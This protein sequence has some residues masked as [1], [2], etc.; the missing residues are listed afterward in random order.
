MQ[1]TEAGIYDGL[2]MDAY[3]ADCAPAPS[4]SKGIMQTLIERSPLHARAEHPRFGNL[5]NEGS[6]EADQGSAIHGLVCGGAER[7][8]WVPFND[9]RKDDAKEM[10][11]QARASGRIPMLEKDRQ[12]IEDCAGRIT[13]EVNRL[14][15]EVRFEQTLVWQEGGVWH[16][17][18]PDIIADARELIV[19]LKTAKNAEP[20]SWCKASLAGTAYDIQAVHGVA[21]MHA[22]TGK[23]YGFHFLVAEVDEPFAISEVALAAEYLDLAQRKR[24]RA[25]RLWAKCLES[26]VWPGYAEGPHYADVPAYR[27]YEFENRVISGAL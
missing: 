2:P 26:G 8:A 14:Y 18:R 21:G 3:I 11:D 6:V 13:E 17:T 9:Y 15:G 23:T 12:R 7:I 4:L 27:V 22:L 25:T 16:R 19:D 20:I 24:E 5:S 10:R 1:L